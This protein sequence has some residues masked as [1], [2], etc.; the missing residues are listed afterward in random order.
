MGKA[1]TSGFASH[2]A[3]Q[4]TC[5]I[6]IQDVRVGPASPTQRIYRIHSFQRT[7]MLSMA[8]GPLVLRGLAPDGDT[9]FARSLVPRL[10]PNLRQLRLLFRSQLI[11]YPHQQ[12]HLRP[13]DLAL[14]RQHLLQLCQRRLLFHVRLLNE[15]N[16]L[17][18]FVLQ[19]PLPLGELYLRLADFRLEKG[20]L[21]LAQSDGLLVLDHQ[22]RRKK[23]LPDRI[24]VR[25]LAACHSS[26]Q[27]QQS[28]NAENFNFHFIPPHSS[29][30]ASSRELAGTTHRV[31][32]LSTKFLA[33]EFRA[34]RR[35][36]L[37]IPPAFA[38][39]SVRSPA[40]SVF[41]FGT[42]SNRVLASP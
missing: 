25:L 23:D 18:H 42:A 19:F 16:E 10:T 32:A 6:H 2:A 21:L 20:F 37:A 38:Q 34:R 12:R 39:R 26:H 15:R 30:G 14:N 27:K 40:Q 4:R 33:R 29:S 31:S 28:A 36:V 9:G 7:L 22:L 5:S 17:F 35:L 13:L 1:G 8:W 24:L 11:L 41:L 3:T